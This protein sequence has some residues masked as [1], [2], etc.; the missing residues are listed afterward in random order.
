MSVS[1]YE[2]LL[3]NLRKQRQLYARIDKLHH[4]RSEL[5]ITSLSQID[6]YLKAKQERKL[7]KPKR[8]SY[9]LGLSKRVTR[10][11]SRTQSPNKSCDEYASPSKRPNIRRHFSL[12]RNTPNC[13]G[14]SNG[15]KKETRGRKPKNGL[16]NDLDDDIYDDEDDHDDEEGGSDQESEF[17]SDEGEDEGEEFESIENSEGLVEEDSDEELEGSNE[18]GEEEDGD[19]EEDDDKTTTTS[20]NGSYMYTVNEDNTD[21]AGIRLRRLTSRSSSLNNASG[22]LA[23]NGSPKSVKNGLRKIEKGLAKN[24]KK[25]SRAAQA[26]SVLLKKLKLKRGRPLKNNSK[27]LNNSGRKLVSNVQ[28]R[29]RAK[30]SNSRN[31]GRAERVCSMPGY[32]LLSENEKK[33]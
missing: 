11:G 32:N 26:A 1:D 31:N 7:T 27:L 10:G 29:K 25:T 28:R 8:F 16:H 23:S 24:K 33:V 13:H 30:L 5:G 3:E 17:Q 9:L 20:S 14:K 12:Y 6:A 18:E 22:I 4:Y 15:K 21:V 19:D 2:T